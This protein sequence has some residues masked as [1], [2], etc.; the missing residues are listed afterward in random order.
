[1]KFCKECGKE[2]FDDAMICPNCGTYQTELHKADEVEIV[3][4]AFE[5]EEAIATSAEAAHDEIES[6]A[7]SDI[8]VGTPVPTFEVDGATDTKPSEQQN[9]SN[10]Y[11]YGQQQSYNYGQQNYTYGQQNNAYG[12]SNAY[13]PGSA[14]GQPNPQGA[15]YSYG[16]EPG[17]DSRFNAPGGGTSYPIPKYNFW[18]FFFL[19][20]ITCGIFGIYYMYKWTEDANRLS[21]G[22][23]KPSMNY[24]LVFLLGL[25]T[26]GIYPLVWTY[27]QGE[28]LKVVGDANGIQINETGVHHLLL[29]LL[30]GG[31][32]GLVSTYIFFNNTNRLAGVYN[33]TLTRDQANQKPSHV[34]AIIIGVILAII[35]GAVGIGT[36]I[37][38]MRNFDINN[39]NNVIYDLDDWEDYD[40][41]DFDL[42]DID[43]DDITNNY[44]FSGT[45]ATF[46]GAVVQILDAVKV[47]DINGDPALAVRFSWDNMGDAKASAMWTFDIT[48]YQDGHKLEVTSPMNGDSNVTEAQN[49]SKNIE[50]GD[51]TTFQVVFKLVNDKD[52]VQVEVGKILSGDGNRAVCTFTL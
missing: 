32:G 27:Q 15:A 43:I 34:A 37:Y 3:E 7:L 51:D 14:Y 2:M 48:A 10:N 22:V 46:D 31:V 20:M 30:L 13:G 40:W 23:Y 6:M 35:T 49:F 33:G 12:Q 17:G 24:I 29:T 18:L 38:Q 36:A 8:A 1:M 25:V 50:P 47:K 5:A 16:N 42:D 41:D 44:S 26:C 9:Q 28:R 45:D 4:P 21:Q 19:T 11:K 52:D 39:Y